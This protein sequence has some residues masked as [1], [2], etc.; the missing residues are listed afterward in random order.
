MLPPREPFKLGGE[1]GYVRAATLF[2]A[3]A[4]LIAMGVDDVLHRSGP[5]RFVGVVW[6]AALWFGSVSDI[7]VMLKRRRK[8]Y[9]LFGAHR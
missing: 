5:T 3:G 6:G 4:L 9:R 8:D 2:I 7:V 1:P